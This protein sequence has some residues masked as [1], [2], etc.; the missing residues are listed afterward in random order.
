LI[1]RLSLAPQALPALSFCST[2]YEGV[3]GF[4]ADLPRTNTAEVLNRLYKALPEIAGVTLDIETKIALL[5][6]MRPISFE[7]TDNLTATSDINEQNIRQVSPSLA[8]RKKLAM[9]HKAVAVAAAGTAAQQPQLLASSLHAA[10]TV[11]SKMLTPC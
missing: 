8:L 7:Y 1:A 9:G 10:I 2:S 4:I 5:E 11:L 3:Q 6:L